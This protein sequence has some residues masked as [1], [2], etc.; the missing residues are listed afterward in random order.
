MLLSAGRDKLHEATEMCL[1]N[2]GFRG[3]I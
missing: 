1:P 3:S 2:D